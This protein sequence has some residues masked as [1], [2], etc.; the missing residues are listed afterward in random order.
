[1]AYDFALD[2]STRSHDIKVDLAAKYGY[3]ER[4]T[5][6]EG[7]GLWFDQIGS[8]LDYLDPRHLELVDYDGVACLP[9][10]VAQALAWA[11]FALDSNF[12]G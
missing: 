10:D 6:G 3:F 5:N 7:G 12:W 1:M 11:G 4:N 2:C 9:K 8:N